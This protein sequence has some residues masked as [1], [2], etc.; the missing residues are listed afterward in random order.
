MLGTPSNSQVPSRNYPFFKESG[1][2]I[3]EFGMLGNPHIL[4]GFDI[5]GGDSI[6]ANRALPLKNGDLAWE[7]RAFRLSG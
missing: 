6:I 1:G 3:S 7:F 5:G 2:Q 4:R